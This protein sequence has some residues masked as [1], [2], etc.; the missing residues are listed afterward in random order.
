MMSLKAGLLAAA[1]VALIGATG[2]AHAGV[3]H[4]DVYTGDIGSGFNAVV[5]STSLFTSANSSQH[6]SFTY[7]G[8]LNFSSTA[9]QNTTPAGDL[10][11]TFFGS[12]A[13]G[14]TGY[15]AVTSLSGSAAPTYG[16]FATLSSFLAASGSVAGYG[17]GSLYIIADQ[18]SYSAGTKLSITHDDGVG[19]YANATLLP[20]TTTG[21]TVAVTEVATLPTATA[22]T[23]A[24]G[25]ENGTPSVLQ[26]A[27]A[28]PVSLSL[29][30]MGLTGL[31]FARRRRG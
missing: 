31:A 4:V 9:A 26:V 16:S 18:S 21:P 28:E 10:N 2:T 7:T 8:P 14:I 12:N 19:V 29:L 1:C 20:G 3:Y 5:G 13:S 22:Y 30:G 17:Y 6:A 25:R 15:T 24:Y 11:S 27:V 23:L